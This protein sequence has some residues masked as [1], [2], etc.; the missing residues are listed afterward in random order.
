MPKNEYNKKDVLLSILSIINSKEETIEHNNLIQTLNDIYYYITNKGHDI[1][2]QKLN[3][4]NLSHKIKELL[5]TINKQEENISK[6]KYD[7][8]N[9][10]SKKFQ[11][12]LKK[13]KENPIEYVKIKETKNI[14]F[15]S[16]E[17]N[18]P[19]TEYRC[20]R[21]AQA[22]LDAGYESR[23]IPCAAVS[24]DDIA[25]ADI[26]FLWRVEFSG[27]VSTI[28]ELC[29]KDN[30]KTVFDTDDIV[31]VPHYARINIIDGIRSIGAT[32]E[33]I[34]RTFADMRRTLARCAFG[35][36][37]TEELATEMHALQPSVHL[38]PNVYNT[39]TLRRSRIQLRLRH[40]PG[41]NS[42]PLELIRIGYATGS[43]THQRDFARASKAIAEILSLYPNVRLVLF[44]EKDNK[45]PVLLIEEFPE[46]IPV[47]DQIEWR[48]MT[49]L[50]EL[51]DEFAR[52]DISIAPLESN[53][54]FCEAKSE[55]KFLEASL[56]GAASIVART[57]PFLR[58]VREGETGLFADTTEEWKH[59]L[60]TLIEDPSMRARIA[61]NAYHDVLFHFGPAAQARR[62]KRALMSMENE[63]Q[64]ALAGELHFAEA[65]RERT[66]LPIIPESETLFYSDC[67]GEARVTV[68]I[69]SYNYADY[70]LEA[71]NSVEAQTEYVLDLIVVDDGSIDGSIDLARLWMER[72]T[73]RFN[74]LVLRRSC[75]NSGLGGARNIGMDAA[76]TP[77]ILHLDADNRL[78]PDACTTLANAMETTTA[79]TYPK[80]ECFN[81][82]GAVIAEYDPDFPK[83]PG[84]PLFLSDLT[85]N[86]FA[87]IS[88]NQIDAMALVS[89]WA[90]A[91]V[92]GYYVSREAMGWEDFD[93]WCSFAERGLP[94]KHVPEI[95][96]DYRHHAS[97]MTNSST[98]STARKPK[99]VDFVQKR[100]PWIRLSVA[101]AK[102]RR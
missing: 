60:T 4:K 10:K 45:K 47:S 85:Y 97:A 57:G 26:A 61:R 89:K 51:A 46:L 7:I 15:I 32:E 96:A 39:E 86:P 91:A 83:P 77:Y 43:R 69:T 17:P 8:E 33:K 37:T 58:F 68:V 75:A 49:T 80:I 34:E 78:R 40:E 5:Y 99:I 35:S 28:L 12:N 42:D 74:R 66:P 76:E 94:G 23:T 54:V 95:L 62:M 14:L 27:H 64:A 3:N 48:D 36:T 16:G 50:S 21:N 82:H 1:F 29:A 56:A 9:I 67:Y 101:N 44:R 81:E 41:R 59:A 6:Y 20:M 53:N 65:L 100:H 24:Y 71:L 87:L 11:F 90:W 2:V 72:H 38:L 31:F 98:E 102:Q 70:L 88:G 92:G 84:T 79:F 93:L 73:Q 30:V 22:C 55:V 25:W 19:G 63:H 13:N 52:F 18:T